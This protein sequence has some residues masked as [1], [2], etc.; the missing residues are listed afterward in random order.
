MRRPQDVERVTGTDL[1]A[2]SLYQQDIQII[3]NRQRWEV[4]RQQ[5]FQVDMELKNLFNLSS[6][7]MQKLNAKMTDLSQTGGA[8]IATQRGWQDCFSCRGGS[9]TAGVGG[10]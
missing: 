6:G 2:F 5:I 1:H 8:G 4:D 7:T 3:R 10:D 9:C